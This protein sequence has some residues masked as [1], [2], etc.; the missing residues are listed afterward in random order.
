MKS[1]ELMG[2][3]RAKGGITP[4]ECLE[5]FACMRLAARIYELR[6]YGATL[7]TV[8]VKNPMTGKK[9]ARYIWVETPRNLEL[10]GVKS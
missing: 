8:M 5:E 6:G 1:L 3:I 4:L 10:A 2:Y 9:H 7:P